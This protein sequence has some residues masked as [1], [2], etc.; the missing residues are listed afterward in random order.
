VRERADEEVVASELRLVNLE[1]IVV[2]GVDEG[3]VPVDER[4]GRD[5]DSPFDKD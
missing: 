4:D 5:A 3:V 2:R 1:E